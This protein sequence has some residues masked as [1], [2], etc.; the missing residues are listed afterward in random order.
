MN[1]ITIV[2]KKDRTYDFYI[3]NNMHMIEGKLKRMLNE[4]P[5]LINY[6]PVDWRHPL[7]RNYRNIRL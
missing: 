6:T 7:S 1:F 4:N 5:N 3:K 2:N